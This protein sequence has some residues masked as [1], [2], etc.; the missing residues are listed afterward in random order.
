MILI[1]NKLYE[2]CPDC[3][4]IVQ[5]NK[6]FFGSMHICLTPEEQKLR[7]HK[8]PP[9]VDHDFR[10]LKMSKPD[11]GPAFPCTTGSDGGVAFDGMSLRKWYAG[12]A[13]SG[14]I[15]YAYK[16]GPEFGFEPPAT[17]AIEAFALADAMITEGDK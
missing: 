13:L 9:I 4:K 3:G 17:L 12:M 11:G 16:R 14:M 6:F 8:Y 10:G 2:R 5:L 1:G 7:T 15:T